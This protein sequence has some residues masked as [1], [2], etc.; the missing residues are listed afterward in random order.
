MGR[1]HVCK[2][3]SFLQNHGGVAGGSILGRRMVGGIVGRVGQTSGGV[4]IENC[5]NR[6][7]V[8]STDAKGVG[9]IVGAGWG[10]GVIRGC[11][12][13]GPIST[14]YSS[15]AGGIIGTNEG[16]DIYN[17]YNAA[18]IDSNGNQRGRGIGSHDTGSYTVDN[19]FY[20]AGCGAD[21]AAPGY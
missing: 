15:P 13:A 8:K 2:Q 14:T 18:R 6:A 20:L 11:Y 3:F 17:C 12:N 4:V 5:A 9:G 10:K 7:A 1:T 19:C 16:L 21:P